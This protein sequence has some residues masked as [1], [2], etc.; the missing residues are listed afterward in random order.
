MDPKKQRRWRP[1][2][3]ILITSAIILNPSDSKHIGFL[4]D[5]D[6]QSLIEARRKLVRDDPS[7]KQWHTTQSFKFYDGENA[8]INCWIFS[9]TE[10]YD[11]GDR[12][13]FGVLGFVW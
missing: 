9:Y 7:L 4:Q 11:T 12:A 1:L 13:S 2:M 6:I 5:Q 10:N 8:Y 3:V